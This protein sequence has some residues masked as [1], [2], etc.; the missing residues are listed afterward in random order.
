MFMFQLRYKVNCFSPFFSIFHHLCF[1]FFGMM[2]LVMLIKC[3]I[4]AEVKLTP[5]QNQLINK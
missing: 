5:F 4:F 3:F 2:F 1:S